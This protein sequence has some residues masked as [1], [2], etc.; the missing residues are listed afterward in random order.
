MKK[1]RHT[2]ELLFLAFIDELEK[3]L[4]ITKTDEVGKLKKKFYNVAFLKKLR[5]TPEDNIISHLCT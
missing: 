2:S 5:K 4:L 1:V 3:Q